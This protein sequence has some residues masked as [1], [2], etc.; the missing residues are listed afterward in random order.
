MK[1]LAILVVLFLV[2]F[3]ALTLVYFVAPHQG[4]MW[5][6]SEVITGE[7]LLLL[8]AVL[9]L[10]PLSNRRFGSVLERR[11]KLA[12]PVTALA[13]L[14][15]ALGSFFFAF[16]ALVDILGGY[17]GP[18]TALSA[19][20]LLAAI[21]YGVGF[22]GNFY[23][24]GDKIGVLGFL[25]LCVASSGL[26]ALR[27]K[28]GI[29]TALREGATLFAAPAIVVFEFA[30]WYCAP[31]DMYWHVAKFAY[32]SLARYPSPVWGFDWTGNIYLFSNWFVLIAA[33]LLTLLGLFPTRQEQQRT[34]SSLE[35]PL[36]S[37]TRL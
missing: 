4:F 25:A 21:Y 2:A 30:L 22:G 34:L 19:Y 14:A 32:W 1:A 10:V 16:M 27:V 23:L 13:V 8:S 3:L 5:A 28:H 24:Y 15:M 12:R 20:P 35:V 11:V 6:Y 7:T 33:L 37:K 31:T 17:G 29:G 26:V 18:G 9:L 36:D